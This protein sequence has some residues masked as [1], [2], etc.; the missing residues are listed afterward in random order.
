MA[1]RSNVKLCSPVRNRSPSEGVTRRKKAQPD[2]DI[3]SSDY[4]DLAKEIRLL[5]QNM[6]GLHLKLSE[7]IQS[8]QDCSKRMDDVTTKMELMEERLTSLENQQAKE[9]TELKNQVAALIDKVNF[10]EQLMLKNEVEVVGVPETKHESLAHTVKVISNK[11]GVTVTDAEL[12][13]VM[14]VGTRNTTRLNVIRPIVVRFLRK[15]KRDEFI[16]AAKTRKNIN[17]KDVTPDSP[18]HTIFINERLTKQN[19]HLFREARLR[20]KQANFKYCWTK[21]GLIYV[22]QR[23]GKAAILI[24]SDAD[25]DNAFK[26]S[27]DS[28]GNA[29]N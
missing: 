25:L 18:E 29:E 19:R 7:A 4:T 27:N 23:E 17:S 21:N 14:R 22:R 24:R 10:Q 1:S 8:I 26:P 9:N 6:S 11:I 28:P 2:V 5:R 13:S 15:E 20:S 12:D 16:L 3:P